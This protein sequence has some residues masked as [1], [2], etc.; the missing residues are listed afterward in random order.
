MQA[1]R[2]SKDILETKHN[3]QCGTDDIIF[4]AFYQ[5]APHSNRS[6]KEGKGESA[7]NFLA[8][9]RVVDLIF[10]FTVH[11]FLFYFISELFPVYVFSIR[12]ENMSSSKKPLVEVIIR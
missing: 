1:V 6:D 8:L 7:I 3:A 11:L 5:L 2:H 10:I 4:V 12:L 9:I